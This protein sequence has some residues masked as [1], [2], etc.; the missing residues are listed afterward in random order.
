ML[1][2]LVEQCTGIAEVMN[3]IPVQA[4]IFFRP[5]FHYGLSIGHYCKDRFH[6]RL[7]VRSSQ[8]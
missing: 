8:V 4:C 2:Q 7:F 5:Y 1:G 6:I 3:S